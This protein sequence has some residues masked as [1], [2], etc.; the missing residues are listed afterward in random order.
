MTHH[1]PAEHLTDELRQCV[2]RCSDCHDS[3]LATFAYCV[4]LGGEHASPAHVRALLDC[5]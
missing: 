2:Q 5:A 1:L 3:C 4:E